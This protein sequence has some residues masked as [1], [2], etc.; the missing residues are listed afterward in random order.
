MKRLFF[1]LVAAFSAFL[2][3]AVSPSGT[4][5]I[6]YINTSN[7]API[8]SKE[9][10]LTATYYLDA[11]GLDGYSSIGSAD[12]PL[13]MQ[14]KGRGNYTWSGFNKKPYRLK[15]DSKQPLLGMKKS[16]HFGLLA[17]ADDNLGFLRNTVGFEVSRRL[18][19]AWTPAQEPVEVVLNG[20]YIGLYF[21]TELIR[22]DSDRVNVTEQADNETDPSAITGGWLVEIDNYDDPAQVSIRENCGTGEYMR[23]THK[24]PEVLSEAQKDYLVNLVTAADAAIYADDKSS[25]T[26]QDYID[27]DELAKFYITQE[28]TDNGESFHGS[29]YW[30]K[31]RGADTKM[32][33]G[34]VWDFGNSFRRGTDKFIYDGSNFHQHWIGEIAKFPAFQDAVKAKWSDFMLQFASIEQF[35]NNFTA[36]IASAAARDAERWPEYGNAD[37]SNSRDRYLAYLLAKVNWLNRQWTDGDD[38]QAPFAALYMVG[39]SSVLGNWQPADAPQLFYNSITHTYSRHFDRISQ[40]NDGRGFKII[41]RRSWSGCFEM[42]SNGN[43]LILNEDYVVSTTIND[44][45]ITMNEEVVE[46]VDV[47]VRQVDGNWVVRI[48]DQAGVEATKSLIAVTAAPG[49]INISAPH[50]TQ[51]AIFTLSGTPVEAPAHIFGTATIAVAPGFYIVTTATGT[52]KVVVH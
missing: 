24:T 35:I 48:S 40:L 36:K 7:G 13:S 11:L 23:F 43:P 37:M 17:N 30:H 15:L 21:L 25:T 45:N 46:N 14:I 49:A 22:V 52:H 5:P 3:M 26:W 50:G 47:T 42:C 34:P 27:I 51:A 44:P 29:C 28:V 31:E 8:T 1:S 38:D 6:F 32:I 18:G 33:F 16:K 10:Y 9:D 20:D 12:A 39:A 2:L 41:D 4:L 19:L